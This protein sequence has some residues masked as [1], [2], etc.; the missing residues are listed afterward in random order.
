MDK[1]VTSVI[2]ISDITEVYKKI[3]KEN[4]FDKI[5]HSEQ[6]DAYEWGLLQFNVSLTRRAA[7]RLP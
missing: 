7:N 5:T 1:E 4:P 3:T 6:H 2:C